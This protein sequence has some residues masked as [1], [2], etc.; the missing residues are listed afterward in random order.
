MCECVFLEIFIQGQT[1]I[2]YLTNIGCGS[3]LMLPPQACQ[4]QHSS[5]YH[6]KRW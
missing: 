4:N 6:D 3:P 1:D 2:R 5:G